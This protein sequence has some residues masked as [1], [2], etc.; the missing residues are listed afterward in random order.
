MI[1]MTFESAIF[2]TPAKVDLNI[3]QP[4]DE[5]YSILVGKMQ[6][7]RRVKQPGASHHFPG[8]IR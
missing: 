3:F 8:F 7:D 6:L 2:L 1:S 5:I 4:L